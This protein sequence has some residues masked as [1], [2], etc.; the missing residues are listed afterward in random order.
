[1]DFQ[2]G[3]SG[4]KGMQSLSYEDAR[5][6]FECRFMDR[7]RAHSEAG[8]GHGRGSG[9]KFHLRNL[10]STSPCS[11]QL[12]SAPQS[13]LQPEAEVAQGFISNPVFRLGHSHWK[14]NAT[15]SGYVAFDEELGQ[16][17]LV[18]RRNGVLRQN[19]LD[20]AVPSQDYRIRFKTKVTGTPEVDLRVNLRFKFKAR[21]G[22]DSPCRK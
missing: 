4:A 2:R 21:K 12:S 11:C 5:G 14:Y 1:M 9:G 8:A 15:R 16:N 18:L 7:R 17:S 20:I 6:Q 22:A 13:R 10:I 19:V 3:N